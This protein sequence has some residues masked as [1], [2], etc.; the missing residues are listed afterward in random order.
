MIGLAKILQWIRIS[1]LGADQI[2]N[3]GLLRCIAV[4]VEQQHI[5]PLLARP[6]PQTVP[7]N[8]K[9]AYKKKIVSSRR[10]FIHSGVL[11]F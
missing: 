8:K 6:K 4:A 2:K 7:S 1:F 5:L 9:P 10:H 3:N 11:E